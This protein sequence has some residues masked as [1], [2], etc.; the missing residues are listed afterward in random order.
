MQRDDL[1]SGVRQTLH[2]TVLVLHFTQSLVQEDTTSLPC[3]CSMSIHL[4]Y[5]IVYVFTCNMI[6]DALFNLCS[7]CMIWLCKGGNA[8]RAGRRDKDFRHSV[9]LKVGAALLHRCSDELGVLIRCSNKVLLRGAGWHADARSHTDRQHF[10]DYISESQK[11]ASRI[12]EV[13][14]SRFALRRCWGRFS[15]A[16]KLPPNY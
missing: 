11:G 6:S 3:F 4:E 7:L 2:E 13:C 1:V 15:E 9:F 12:A 10:M 16:N 14:R 8:F 5:V